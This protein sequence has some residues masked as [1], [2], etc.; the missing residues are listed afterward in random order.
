MTSSYN[1]KLKTFAIELYRINAIKFGEFKTKVGLLTPVY[2]DLRVIVSYPKLME[3]LADLLVENLKEL[4]TFNIICGVPYTALPIATAVSLKTSQP[5]VMRRKE[6]KDY[7]T[8]KLIEGVYKEGDTCLII[9]DVVT[10]GSSILETVKDLT[11][12][13]IKCHDAIVLLNRQQGGERILQNEGIQMRALLNLTQLMTYLKEAGCIDD[14]IVEEVSNYLKHTQ[15]DSSIIKK[16]PSGINRLHLAFEERAKMTKNQ[17]AADLFKI[18]AQKET[19]LCLAADL[20]AAVDILNL[21]ERVGPYICAFKTHIDIVEDFNKNFV[22]NLQSIAKR[23][24]FLLF[25]DRKFADIGKTVELQLT[26]GIFE[27]SQWARLITA[28]SLTG[29]G[30][31]D[32]IKQSS[33]CGVFLLAQTS[34]SGSLINNDYTNATLKLIEDY[35]ETVSGVVCQMPLFLD[36]PGLIQLTPGVQLN[37]KGDS[38]G[39]QYNSPENVVLEQGA[40]VA[41]VGRGITQAADAKMAAV[42]YKTLLW[43]A[44]I[45][46]IHKN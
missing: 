10:S 32:A 26:K 15:I 6:A 39:Q 35:K 7:G 40:D 27:I 42:Q 23:H 33:N 20:T 1:E 18:M 12:A 43:N 44:Y 41:V 45:K 34:A 31:L 17:P 36:N 2:C 8:K 14:K 21:A 9:E 30:V 5:M 24:N 28:H 38:L 37:C 13:G 29:K 11:N 22:E 16:A 4:N 25:E 46:R 3:T 19:N